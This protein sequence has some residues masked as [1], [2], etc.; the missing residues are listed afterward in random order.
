MLPA[1][2]ISEKLS[3]QRISLFKL[4]VNLY[5]GNELLTILS[6]RIFFF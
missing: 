2:G 5:K 6:H 1:D 3:K 4:I